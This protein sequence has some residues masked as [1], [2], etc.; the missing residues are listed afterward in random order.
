M[1]LAGLCHGKRCFCYSPIVNASKRHKRQLISPQQFH[2]GMPSHLSSRHEK[3]TQTSPPTSL[4]AVKLL[5]AHSCLAESAEYPPAATNRC[6]FFACRAMDLQ[7]F[8]GP[9]R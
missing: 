1:G 5:A 4:E 7:K 8:P 9:Q 2:D 6:A 3:L